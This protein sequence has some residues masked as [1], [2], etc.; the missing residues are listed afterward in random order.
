MKLVLI[1]PSLGGGGAERV[2]ATLANAWAVRRNEVTLITLTSA[3]DDRYPLDRTVWRMALD[4]ARRSS[5]P[6]QALGRNVM[7]VRALRRAI[8]TARPDAVISFVAN[9]NAL[10]MM[11]ATGLRVPVIVTERQFVG[12][13]PS[14]R[15]WAI[16]RLLLYRSAAA[17]VAQPRRCADDL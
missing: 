2:M 4:V 3:K 8:K 10:A 11:A 12:A 15:V 9:T 6:V 5:N 16:L 7:R 1:V 13:E 17:V 14:R